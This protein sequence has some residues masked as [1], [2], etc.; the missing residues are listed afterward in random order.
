MC[1]QCSIPDWQESNTQ[2]KSFLLRRIH[3]QRYMYYIIVL[4]VLE[5]ELG[6]GFDGSLSLFWYFSHFSKCF[7]VVLLVR[8]A[9]GHNTHFALGPYLLVVFTKLD[10]TG[11]FFL[12]DIT[13]VNSY[14]VIVR[15]RLT[16]TKS[17]GGI[18]KEPRQ[19]SV[20]DSV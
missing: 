8:R 9:R 18:F 7:L 6:P 3:F 14:N 20:V 19:I 1:V 16:K 10:Q 17:F 5:F 12:P 11:S 4:L 13:N 15:A 2:H